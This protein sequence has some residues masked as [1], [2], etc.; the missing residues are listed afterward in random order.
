MAYAC[1]ILILV[2]L[3][4]VSRCSCCSARGRSSAATRQANSATISP[5]S[6]AARPPASGAT[7]D[8]LLFGTVLISALALL[9]SFFVSVGIALFI[10]HYAPKKLATAL[11]Y[12][13]DL[14]AAIPSVIYGLWGGLVLV[15]AI[16]PFWN[17][18]AKYL[19]W[20]PTVRRSRRQSLPYRGHRVRG[21]G[22]HD[23]ADHHLH[24]PR[25]LPADPSP[26]GRGRA[27]ARRHEVGNGSSLAVLPF[28][29]SGVVSA[30]MLGSRPC[31]RRDDGR[32][33]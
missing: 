15:P 14:L 2:V 32:A 18:V 20:I 11:S 5:T 29:K 23:P 19:G 27:G 30:S 1:G 16:Y 25:H 10:S 9:I 7:S 22:R 31:A 4:A 3:A 12:V 33:A 26:S 6:P 21:A 8:P 28:G 24:V 13:V 17:W